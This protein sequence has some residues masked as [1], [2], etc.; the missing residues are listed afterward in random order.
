MSHPVSLLLLAPQL[1]GMPGG[2]Q[3]YMRRLREILTAYGQVCSLPVHC[4]S[5]VDAAEQRELHCHPVQHS[6]FEGCARGKVAFVLKAA[7]HVL[8]RRECVAVV[9]HIGQAPVAWMLQQLNLIQSYILVLHG[10]E[11]WK[12]VAWFDRQAARGAACIIATTRYTAQEFCGYNGIPFERTRII[13]LAVAEEQIELPYDSQEG[14]GD[15]RILTV[16]RLSIADRYKGFDILIKAIERARTEGANVHLTVVGNGDDLPRLRELTARMGLARHVT[17]F[18][19]MP[20]EKLC[21]LYQECNVFAMPSSKEGFGIVFLEAMRHGKPCIGGNHGGT[22][23]VIDHGVDGYLV[24]YGDVTQ[25]THYLVELSQNAQLRRDMGL[26]GYQ[27]VKAGYL[28]PHMWDNW[29]ALLNQTA[30]AGRG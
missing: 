20:D 26:K 11:A 29:F 19:A 10:I 1:Y 27:K 17:F 15:L 8:W 7:R 24:N 13:P 23:E 18:E 2:V 30:L 12:K 9:G 22:P 25:L 21:L 5:L 16:G 14:N 3:V 4:L 6:T 28:F